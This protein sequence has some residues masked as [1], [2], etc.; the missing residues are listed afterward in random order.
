MRRT[1]YG[2]S[3]SKAIC[4]WNRNRSYTADAGQVI[5]DLLCKDSG[6]NETY[7]FAGSG[8]ISVED[9]ARRV[10][11]AAGQKY[12]RMIVSPWMLWTIGLFSPLMR[13][14]REMSY[15]MTTPVNLKDD[16]LVRHLGGVPRTSYEDGIAATLKAYRVL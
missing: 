9:F 11:A 6:W 16:K 13:E 4:A 7:N 5:G 2:R 8:L 3:P 15:L 14:F 10:Y 12:R 1:H